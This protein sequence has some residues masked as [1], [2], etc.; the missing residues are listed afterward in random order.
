V[1]LLGAVLL[2]FPGAV[3]D[4]LG[5]VGFVAVLLTQRMGRRPA[6]APAASLE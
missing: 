5:V 4:L 6:Q 3:T 2:I 1:L